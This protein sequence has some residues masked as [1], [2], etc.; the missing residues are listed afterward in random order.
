MSGKERRRLEVLGRV[1]DGK[2]SAAK[3]SELTG[4]GLRQARRA[5]KRFKK[6]GDAGLIHKLRGRAGN[7]AKEAALRRAVSE[8]CRERYPDFG[9]T[10]AAEKLAEEGHVVRR[11]TPCGGRRR[12]AGCR[13]RGRGP[14]G[15]G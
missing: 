8:R 14:G 1:R 3:A 5:W 11:E 12:G 13:P 15:V 10:P 7:P 9:P 4:P 2:L 6:E